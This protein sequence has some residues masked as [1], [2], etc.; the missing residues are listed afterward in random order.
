[1]LQVLLV[2]M[3]VILYVVLNPQGSYIPI[4]LS[5]LVAVAGAC[6]GSFLNVVVWRFP[7]MIEYEMSC[8]AAEHLGAPAPK[9]QHLNLAFPRSHCPCCRTTLSWKDL[10][11]VA[12]WLILRGR[13]RYCKSSI[14]ARYP[15]VELLSA[16]LSV[17]TLHRYGLSS[18]FG[19]GLLTVWLSL[20][21]AL[22]DHDTTLLPD[23]LT[24]PLLWLALGASALGW[25]QVAPDA[26][27]MGAVVGYGVAAG[28]G[29]SASYVLGKE[30][31]GRGDWKYLAASG[32]LLGPLALPWVALLASGSALLVVGI[33]H[34]RRVVAPREIPL[35]PYLVAA[36]L[37][38]MLAGP[39][40]SELVVGVGGPPLPVALRAVY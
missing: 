14:A 26:A 6:V 4:E 8:A 33:Q 19:V 18:A 20:S 11:P 24:L 39:T 35:G 12:S 7:Q 37:L 30:A 23:E 21:A 36:T 15:L 34:L 1:M 31:L 38:L 17:A 9:E 13:C 16:A 25:G 3:A 10:L 22:I 27:I 2:S 29:L 5:V 32:A 40:V 28:L